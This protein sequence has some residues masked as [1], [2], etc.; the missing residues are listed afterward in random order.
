MLYT[1]PKKVQ[2]AK[3]LNRRALGVR[4]RNDGNNL[5][6]LEVHRDPFRIST[7]KSQLDMTIISNWLN[8]KSYWAT[9]RSMETIKLLLENSL[10]FRVYE[11][12]KT[13]WIRAC[14]N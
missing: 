10:C 13:I 1:E 4:M 12:I 6:N 11:K 2:Q 9:N 8:N 5:I 7:D 3:R 14:C